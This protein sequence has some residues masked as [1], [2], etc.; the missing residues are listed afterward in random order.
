MSLI[1]RADLFGNPDRATPQVSPDGHHLSWLAPDE[2][3]LN[4]WVAPVTDPSAARAVTQ[5]RG[6]GVRD[7]AWAHDSAHLLYIQDEGGD[8]NWH[9]HAVRADGSG[10]RDLTPIEGVQARLIARSRLHP[11]HVVVGL[12]DRVAQLHDPV[13]IDLRTGERERIL[14]NPGFVQFLCDQDLAPRIA[15]TMTPD[16]GVAI[17]READGEWTP[18]VQAPQADSLTTS[19]VA[20]DR[21][22]T[23]L[24]LIDSRDR[25][26]AAAFALDLTTGERTLLAEDPRAD[27]SGLLIHPVERHVQAVASTFERTRW[28]VLDPAIQPDLDAL[29]QQAGGGEVAILSR[30]DADETWTVA[31][32]GDDG[33]VRYGLWRRQSRSW[34]PLFTNRSALEGRTLARMHPVVLRSRDDL[35]LVSYLTLPHDADP[36]G[37]GRPTGPLPLVLVVHG[38]PWAR[39]GWGYDPVHQWLANRGYAV[40]SV[41]FRGSTGFGKAFLNAG[42]RAWAAEMHDDLL[43]AVAW[44][45]GQ[46]IADPDRVG[47]M[48]G[49]YGGYATLVGLTFTPETF[50]CGVDIVGPSDI[51]TLI[52]SIPEYWKPLVAQFHTRVGDPTTPEGRDFLW[53]RSPLSRVEAIRRPLLIGQGAND[54]RVRQVESDQIVSAMQERGIPVTYVLFPDEGHGF[55][56]PKNRLAFYGIAEA[57]LSRHLGGQV[58]PLGDAVGESTARIPEGA[59]QV[60]GLEDALP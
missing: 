44:A 16:G 1:P 47:I 14:E 48:G 13:R 17:F 53:S 20:L 46:G 22:G 9:L 4:L 3:V 59:D 11:H 40:L 34:N 25:N 15:A 45:V 24:F 29:D 10:D 38:G 55:A 41:N 27:V 52:E 32:V 54:P 57:F 5:D 35:D 6:R 31:L 21:A 19:P 7:Y 43:D 36:D 8:E 51:R 49:S 12:N 30:D 33:P 50:A 56:R 26:T 60:P 23:T 42:D 58:E 28:Q 37:T 2:G 39:D 18:L